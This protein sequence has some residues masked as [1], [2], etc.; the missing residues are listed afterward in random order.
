MEM[1]LLG[2]VSCPLVS[3]AVSKFRGAGMGRSVDEKN[4]VRGRAM[5]TLA[6]DYS[7]LMKQ[8]RSYTIQLENNPRS[9]SLRYNR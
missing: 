3:D 2:R 6:R 9:I 7:M 8:Q 1:S 4:S 5:V